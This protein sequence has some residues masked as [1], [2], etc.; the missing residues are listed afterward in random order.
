MVYSHTRCFLQ[1]TTLFSKVLGGNGAKDR[2]GSSICGGM[3]VTRLARSYGFFERGAGSF[4]TMMHTRPFCVLLYKRTRIIEDNRVGNF[5]IPDDD[6]VMV[7]EQPG[8]RVRPRP[9]PVHEEPLVIP[10][11]D[12]MPMNPNNLSMRKFQDN[13]SHGENHTNMTLEFMMSQINMQCPDSHPPY[14]YIPS[15]EDIWRE[16]QGRA[17]GS[18]ARGG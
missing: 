6:E 17:G 14:S 4:L 11:E 16:R 15:W 2:N 5:S 7:P 18:E 3:L 8:R 1:H 12:E 10:V 9:E 13:L